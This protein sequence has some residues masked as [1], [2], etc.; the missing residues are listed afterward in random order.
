MYVGGLQLVTC[1]TCTLAQGGVW[2]NGR[3]WFYAPC[4]RKM[5]EEIKA[6]L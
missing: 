1:E 4:F 3:W 5:H 6:N 2:R